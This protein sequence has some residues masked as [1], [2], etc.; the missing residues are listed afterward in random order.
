M[1]HTDLPH[2]LLIW[3]DHASLVQTSKG[4]IINRVTTR[5]L[6]YGFRVA[7]KNRY[8]I[9]QETG[10]GKEG[11]PHRKEDTR[12]W[13][14]PPDSTFAQTI[15]RATE[16]IEVIANLP[17]VKTNYTREEKEGVAHE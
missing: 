9:Y 5:V 14:M 1:I 15:E 13:F 12:E 7:T 2:S 3:H 6:I 4:V 17:T 16:M 10:F 11:D 8:L